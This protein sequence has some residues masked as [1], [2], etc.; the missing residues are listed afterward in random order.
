MIPPSPPATAPS[1]SPLLAAPSALVPVLAAVAS[2]ALG[3]QVDVAIPGT[4]VPQSLQTLAVVV[5][6]GLLGARRGAGALA[7][8]ALLG[9]AGLPVFAGGASG[10]ERLVGP[11]GGFLAGFVAA[12]ALAGAWRERGWC[13]RFVPALGGMLLAHVVILGAGWGRLALLVGAGAAWQQGVAP[14]L[15]GG[16]LKAAA[17]AGLLRVL[18]PVAALTPPPRDG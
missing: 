6:G 12:A 3:A 14:F 5:A 11:T 10:V 1:A 18:S 16:V 8:Y 9:A 13:A 17:A 4:P 2:V 7:L 15:A